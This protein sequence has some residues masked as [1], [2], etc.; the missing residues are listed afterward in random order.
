MMQVGPHPPSQSVC[1]PESRRRFTRFS[2]IVSLTLLAFV[3]SVARAETPKRKK[4][5]PAPEKTSPGPEV[6]ANPASIDD[7]IKKGVAYIYSQQ[8]PG[9]HWEETATRIGIGHDWGKT[10]GDT[11]GG[12]TSLATYA[13][14]AAGESPQD[15]RIAGAVEFLKK[16]D[17]IGIYSLGL[18]A[19]VWH[20]LAHTPKD[21]TELEKYVNADAERIIAGVNIT[22]DN[23]GLWDYGT[24][25]GG[26]IDH[27]V[28]QYG[29]L[30]LWALEEAGAKVDTRY[31]HTFDEVWRQGQFNDGGWAYDATPTHRSK[32]NPSASM[33]AAGI[34]TLF[35]T[36]DKTF[37]ELGEHRG[38]VFNPNI[39][40]GL[41]WMT[42]HFGE[43][44]NNYSWY[45]VERIGVA[46]GTKYFG[47]TDWFQKGADHL[48]S[49]QEKDGHWPGHGVGN[50]LT[51]T[52]FAV[53]FLS[54]GRAP[55]MMNKLHYEFD[56][57]AKTVDANWNDRP[58]DVA[59]LAK[60]TSDQIEANLNWQLVTLDVPAEELRDAPILYLSGDQELNFSE[61]NE[62]KL[63][64]FITS[65]G[66]ILGNADFNSKPFSD[67]FLKL[68]SKLFGY[69][70][71]ELPSNSPIFHEDAQ[72]SHSHTKVL[73]LSNGI[74]ELMI[75]FQSGDP[76]KA[77]QTPPETPRPEPLEL[78]GISFF[79]Q[80][81]RKIC[82]ARDRAIW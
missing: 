24:G 52:C 35:I 26:R 73:A 72:I 58:R 11:F 2:V 71:R 28:S 38:N 59:N 57:T 1:L 22:G 44:E 7:A 16:A 56:K 67:S 75:L 27:S 49:T 32:N 14:L 64:T 82:S 51:D 55:I 40:N 77:W 33:T 20:L 17:V 8:K 46:S 37:A 60:F 41:R 63:K 31:W 65:G 48:V 76:A 36:Q 42:K 68:G 43:V 10:Q 80:W 54:R 79:T 23:R 9:G 53:L 25:K 39:E 4:Q 13:L 21:Q 78:G 29:I 12:F 50:S 62:N 66:M 34:A 15:K 3:F 45:G 5:P 30:G 6:T 74:R 18:R 70:F 61:A 81:I 19:Q 47:T 69:E